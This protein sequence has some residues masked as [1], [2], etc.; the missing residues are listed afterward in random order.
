MFPLAGYTR[1]EFPLICKFKEKL[2][3]I[4]WWANFWWNL[5]SSTQLFQVKDHYIFQRKHLGKIKS[6]RQMT[7]CRYWL[8]EC[9]RTNRIFIRYMNRFL[10]EL[11]WYFMETFQISSFLIKLQRF[12]QLHKDKYKHPWWTYRCFNHSE[13]PF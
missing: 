5:S 1:L 13:V 9:S 12:A 7:S 8:Q 2:E 4:Q 11:I 10:S 6:N 3:L